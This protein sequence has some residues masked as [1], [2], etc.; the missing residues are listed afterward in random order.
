MMG[1]RQTKDISMCGSSLQTLR[2]LL[3]NRPPTDCANIRKIEIED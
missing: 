3:A 2:S 1:D